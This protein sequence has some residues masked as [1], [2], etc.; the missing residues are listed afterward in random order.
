MACLKRFTS[1]RGIPSV[2]Y[3]D[4]GSTFV[5]ANNQLKELGQ[6]LFK[7]QESIGD[8]TCKFNIRW[9]FIP[10][11]TP[12]HGGLWE[13]AVKSTKYHLKRVLTN[14][15][16]TYEEFNTLAIQIEGVLNSRPLFSMSN[17]PN[18]IV[19]ITPSHFLIGRVLTSIP[20]YNLTEVHTNRLSRLQHVQQLYQ[21]FWNQFSKQY[22]SQLHQQYKWKGA[23]CT[24][25]VD[26]LVLIK[27]DS[28]PPCKWPLGR[29]VTLFNG[30]DGI[31][32]IAEIKT[33][34]GTITR[35]VRHLCPIP[36]QTETLN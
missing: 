5:G 31:T 35:S 16:V 25:S 13:A 20:D 28:Q 21:Q 26:T 1:R 10:P 30:K 12:N 18:D 24:I 9:K 36:V 22:I 8:L 3:S 2:L 27:N 23:P 4:N 14:N 33:A 32:R 15:N 17:D 11:Y 34:K 6:F 7:N 29:V 19:P